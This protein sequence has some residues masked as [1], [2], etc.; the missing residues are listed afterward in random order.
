MAIT[1][2]KAET[3]IEQ[4]FLLAEGPVYLEKENA[5]LF[6]DISGDKICRYDLASKKL[7]IIRVG[8]HVGASVPALSGRY[9]TAMTTGIYLADENGLTLVCRPEELVADF[10]LNDAK[11]APDGRFIF[12]TIPLFYGTKEP[13]A[14]LSLSPDGS[15]IKL[16]AQPRISNG[17]AWSGDNKTMYYN[18]SETKGVDAFDYNMQTG[19]IANRRR[20]HTS[21]HTPDGMC[22]DAE[23]MLWVALWGGYKVIRVD[24]S[25]GKIIA[26]IPIPAEFVTSCCFGGE[27][28]STLFIT[29]SGEW[30]TKNPQAGHIFYA[31]V[32]VKGTKAVIFDDS[33]W[34]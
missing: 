11:C 18:D 21:E 30:D 24:P 20:I 12:G 32:G 2:Y 8:Q 14:L 27:D 7:T 1:Q 6:V 31:E 9:L 15:Y 33:K 29:T 25:D 26:E 22:I 3:L 19:E 34:E 4:R 10:R 16:D 17:L 13:G 28:Y 23:D 5:L